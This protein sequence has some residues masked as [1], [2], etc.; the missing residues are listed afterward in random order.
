MS[1]HA[2]KCKILETFR[3]CVCVCLCACVAHRWIRRFYGVSF[4]DSADPVCPVSSV[5]LRRRLLAGLPRLSWSVVPRVLSCLASVSV[6]LFCSCL[7]WSVVPRALPCSCPVPSRPVP[8]SLP[9][10]AVVL[11]ITNGWVARSG[12]LV[13]ASLI[14]SIFRSCFVRQ[15]I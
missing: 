1:C 13:A 10:R 14:S 2:V 15:L 11:R 8:S 3:V 7:S 9:A 6:C 4:R 5:L 12:A